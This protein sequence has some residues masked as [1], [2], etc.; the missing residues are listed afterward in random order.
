LRDGDNNFPGLRLYAAIQPSEFTRLEKRMQRVKGGL[1]Q[2][3]IFIHHCFG[4]CNTNLHGAVWWYIL[5][6]DRANL[7]AKLRMLVY[8]AQLNSMGP[9]H[10]ADLASFLV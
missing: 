5:K 8:W 7:V 2:L 6:I 4:L 3:A 1:K 10:K 9:N